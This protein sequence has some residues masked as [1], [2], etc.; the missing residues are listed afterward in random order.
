MLSYLFFFLH[1]Q[2][3]RYTFSHSI[4]ITQHF[5][6]NCTRLKCNKRAMASL[7]ILQVRDLR[8]K[9]NYPNKCDQVI[10]SRK[11][12]NS[13][14]EE[15]GGSTL[16]GWSGKK[17]KS[18][19]FVDKLHRFYDKHNWSWR[20][21][22]SSPGRAE[23]EGEKECVWRALARG[24]RRPGEACKSRGWKGGPGPDM[25]RP[26]TKGAEL[27]FGSKVYPPKILSRQET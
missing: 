12:L 1:L 26:E 19:F 18:T 20:M 15:Y 11:H 10:T 16:T 17:K 23:G 27:Y 4:R 24:Y 6:S 14:N 25:D 7:I 5:D 21:S 13:K 22:R 9:L 3:L 2:L 8:I